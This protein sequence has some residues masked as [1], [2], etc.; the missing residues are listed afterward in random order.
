MLLGDASLLLRSR[1]RVR[2]GAV[3]LGVLYGAQLY[4]LFTSAGLRF[5][6]CFGADASASRAGFCYRGDY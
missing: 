6:G 3:A 2:R 5:E 1:A 4:G